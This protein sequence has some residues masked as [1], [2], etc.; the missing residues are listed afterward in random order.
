[1]KKK[2]V[3]VFS[4][5]LGDEKN[6]EFIKHIDNTIGVILN[7]INSDGQLQVKVIEL[8]N[9]IQAQYLSLGNNL[10]I[11]PAAFLNRLIKFFPFLDGHRRF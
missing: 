4:S 7:T 9:E 3:V 5:H 8:F 6:N 10:I 1:M 2:I 11:Y